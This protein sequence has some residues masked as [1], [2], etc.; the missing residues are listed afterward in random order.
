M[1]TASRTRKDTCASCTFT[2]AIAGSLEGISYLCLKTFNNW[3]Y[4]WSDGDETQTQHFFFW[5]GVSIAPVLLVWTLFWLRKGYAR[6]P[7][8]QIFP[9]ELASLTIVSVMGGLFV[10]DEADMMSWQDSVWVALGLVILVTAIMAVAFFKSADHEHADDI[11]TA[12]A[13]AVAARGAVASCQE[14]ACAS[15][16]FADGPA[17]APDAV[18]DPVTPL[19]MPLPF[20]PSANGDMVFATA[21]PG[22]VSVD[23][24]APGDTIVADPAAL[25][26]VITAAPP[27]SDEV[28]VADLPGPGTV[29][30]ATQQ[31]M[32]GDLPAMANDRPA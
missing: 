28:S 15:A 24:A 10:H 30:L 17:A 12:A 31:Y 13:P 20:S 9:V 25:G 6:F 32:A 19:S 3:Y 22:E 7:I 16:A 21:V 26:D 2:I 23:P 18:A 14:A 5:T 29:T 27:T 8:T 4:H 11:T 1:N